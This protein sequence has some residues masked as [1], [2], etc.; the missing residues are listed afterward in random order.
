MRKKLNKKGKN[1]D[2]ERGWSHEEHE[3]DYKKT[4]HIEGG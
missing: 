4:K 2:E 1:K 3:L